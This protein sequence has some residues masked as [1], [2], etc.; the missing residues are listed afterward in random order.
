VISVLRTFINLALVASVAAAV[1][2]FRDADFVRFA[3]ASIASSPHRDYAASLERT[4]LSETPL[5]REW[6][7][8]ASRAVAE[9]ASTTLPFTRA[10]V[11]AASRPTAIGYAITLK[12]GQRLDVTVV[13]AADAP[14][15]AFVD[16]F[17]HDAVGSPVPRA[18]GLRALSFEPR[19]DSRLIVRVQPELLSGAHLT[20]RAR[21][22]P[23]L[24]FPVAGARASDLHSVFG[25]DRDGGRRRHEGVDIFAKRGTPVLAASDGI[26]TRV[27]ET[28][29]GGRVVWVWDPSRS[30]SIYYAHLD[31]QRVATGT[32]VRAGDVVGTVG[33]TGNARTTAP[34]LH[35][36]IYERGRGAIDPDAFIRPAKAGPV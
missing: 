34:H 5:G 9:P 21:A 33:N 32:R 27:N 3:R 6:L 36:G 18:H 8:A 10:S 20:V 15:Q 23:A 28:A 22:A 2:H 25:D 26:V 12:R 11:A 19:A 1:W 35:F 29:I 17:E 30:L 24:R 14:A 7:A 31:Q 13:V 4:G 16:V